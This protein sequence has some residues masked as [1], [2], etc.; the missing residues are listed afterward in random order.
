[1]TDAITAPAGGADDIVSVPVSTPVSGDKTP[2][3]LSEAA[4]QLSAYR[5]KR[6]H[7]EEAAPAPAATP[8]PAAPQQAAAVEPPA[9]A[10]PDLAP[11]ANVDP[12]LADPG[13]TT[14][15]ADPAQQPTIEPPRSWSKEEKAE[16]ATYPP[17]AQEKI[18]RREQE[19]DTAIRR[20]QNEAAEQRK[21]IDAE[22]NEVQQARQRY[23]QALPALLN[24][25]QEQQRGEFADIRSMSDVE[26]LAREDWPRYALWDAQQKKIA[27]VAQE[28]QAT[29]QRQAQEY[30]A[31]WN[32]YATKQDKLLMDRVPELT[33]KTKAQRFADAAASVYRNVGFD[34][35][36]LA[37]LWSGKKSISLR[38]A[39]LS[40]IVID[41]ARWREAKANAAKVTKTPP[42]PVQRPGTASAAITAADAEI[43]ALEKAFNKDPSV[44]NAAALRIARQRS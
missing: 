35:A 24:T 1:M 9:Q 4:R 25:L 42:P 27:A 44:K 29:Q 12:L 34:D 6:D 28:V 17:E 18:A 33:D 5:W 37:D 21:A 11:D 10:Q 2:I 13:A 30:S 22:R 31:Q 19:R 38:D 20:A 40:Q 8:A 23:E 16:F 15:V 7:P 26:K 41:A 14:N 3:D 39:R 36:E 32:D 43:Q